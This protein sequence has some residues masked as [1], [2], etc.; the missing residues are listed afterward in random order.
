MNIKQLLHSL[1]IAEV[2][3]GTASGIVWLKNDKEKIKSYS[4]VDG[5]IIA[6][7]YTTC[8]ENYDL[9]I[10]K[11]LEAFRTWRLMPAPKRGEVVR[12]IGEALR[13]KR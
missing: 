10:Q 12:Q 3:P 2:N 5:N 7:I 6:E 13:H 8:E 9:I 4:P 11:S 1:N